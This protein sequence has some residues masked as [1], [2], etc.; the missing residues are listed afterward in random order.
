LCGCPERQL[1]FLSLPWFGFSCSSAFTSRPAASVS[2]F[3]VLHSA[4]ACGSA[5]GVLAFLVLGSSDSVSCSQELVA[6]HFFTSVRGRAQWS[7]TQGFLD[8]RVLPSFFFGSSFRLLLVRSHVSRVV[9]WLAWRASQSGFLASISFTAGCV[10]QIPTTRS[11]VRSNLP[12]AREQTC[13]LP[14]RAR[15][16]CP[17][18]T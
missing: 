18:F 4:R 2:S 12:F 13:G 8:I 11:P 5:L 15:L 17:S 3:S 9:F 14:S 1:I 7:L 6:W 16:G 10:I